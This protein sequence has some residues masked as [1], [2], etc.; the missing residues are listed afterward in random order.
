M[1]DT[2]KKAQNLEELK[3]AYRKLSLKFHPDCGGSDSQMAE[4]NNLYESMFEKLK[5]VHV[6]GKAP[7]D[8]TE[9]SKDFIK[10]INELI[11]YDNINIDIIGSWLWVSGETYPIKDELKSLGFK[12]SKGKSKWYFTKDVTTAKKRYGKKSYDDLKNIYGCETV[13]KASKKYLT[14]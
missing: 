13:Q 11:K 1:F 8:S 9:T 5:N 2:I 4:L 3:K 14:A 10:I 7:K 12:W 6:G